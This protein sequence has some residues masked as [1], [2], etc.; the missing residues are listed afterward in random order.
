MAALTVSFAT[1]RGFVKAVNDVS[2]TVN[3]G[4]ILSIVGESGSGKTVTLLSLLGLTDRRTTQ[5]EGSVL[6]RGRRLLELKDRE[7]RRIRGKEIALISQDP[8]TAL[9]PVH[10]IGWQIVEQIRAHDPV[11]EP[12]ARR[13]AIELLGEVGLP[14]PTEAFT[15]Y[16]HQL[17]GGMRQRAVIAMALSCNPAL[18]VADEPTTALDV[19][20]QAQVLELLKRLRKDF[21]SAIILITHDMGVVAEVADRVL[22]MYAGRVV[23]SG[24]TRQVFEDPWHPYTWGLLASIPPVHGERP[25]RLTSIPGTPPTPTNLPPGCGFAPRC[26]LRFTP[27]DQ[28]PPRQGE[29]DRRALC[30]ISED[31]RPAARATVLPQFGGAA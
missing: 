23:E 28:P 22:V 16:P 11:S 17:S 19:T 15:R 4:E 27:C 29:G 21:G 3:E 18:L 6:F 9:T 7:M 31:R 5:V 30:F 20:V 8:M 12:V 2:F 1:D 14:N 10:T 13:R 25:A 26:R 24:T